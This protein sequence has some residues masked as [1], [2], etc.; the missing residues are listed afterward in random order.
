MENPGEISGQ[1]ICGLDE[2]GRGPLAGPVTAACVL[3]K[4]DFPLHEVA[5][6]KSMTE[7]ARERAFR[8]ILAQAHVGIGWSWPEEID[9][10]NILQASLLAMR[11]AYEAMGFPSTFAYVD[12]NQWPSL[13]I[14]GK[15]VVRG[16]SLIP[17]VSAAS[18][19]AK[20]ARD[21]WMI[22]W[23]W[24]DD[25]YGFEIHKGYPTVAHRRALLTHGPSIIH[26]KSFR[27][28]EPPNYSS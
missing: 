1:R 12:G 6:S 22:R 14:P 15:A 25:R 4:E 2:A 18:I 21:H 24:L 27:W 8:L 3:L 26:R 17:C 5:D 28:K 13:P 9:R 11:R 10:I 23:S 16:D 7:K 20:V 19:V